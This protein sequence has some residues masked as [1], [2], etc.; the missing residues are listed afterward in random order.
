MIHQSCAPAEANNYGSGC[1]SS[2][3]Y[4][5]GLSTN[6]T[7]ILG[8]DIELELSNVPQGAMIGAMA[9]GFFQQSFRPCGHRSARVQPS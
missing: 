7:P 9:L 5:L 3:V 2:S 1:G 6:E 8:R 4:R